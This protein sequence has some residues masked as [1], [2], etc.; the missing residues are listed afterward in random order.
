MYNP[1]SIHSASTSIPADSSTLL[2]APQTLTR[3]AMSSHCQRVSSMLRWSP[4]G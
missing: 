1:P 4:A 3:G 2:V